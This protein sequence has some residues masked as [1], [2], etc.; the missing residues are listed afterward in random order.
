MEVRRE[1]EPN[2]AKLAALR[3]TP[4][5]IE[6][7]RKLAERTIEAN[8]PDDLDRWDR[9]LH[10]KIASCAGNHFFY[11]IFEMIDAVRAEN[12]WIQYREASF[13]NSNREMLDRQHLRIVECIQSRDTFRA[14][15]AKRDHLQTI[16]EMVTRYGAR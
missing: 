14:H 9:A 16:T 3:A 5:E 2:L 7:L 13:F 4:I 11:R 15:D 12:S 8:N 10:A 1:I 6:T